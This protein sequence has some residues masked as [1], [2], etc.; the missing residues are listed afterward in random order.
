[1]CDARRHGDEL[2]IGLAGLDRKQFAH[3]VKGTREL[4]PSPGRG[5]G[6]SVPDLPLGAIEGIGMTQSP[7]DD[8]EGPALSRP[9]VLTTSSLDVMLRLNWV[10]RLSTVMVICMRSLA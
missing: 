4:L 6:R 10:Q 1:M 3:F 8:F 7:I 9:P 5:A 2:G